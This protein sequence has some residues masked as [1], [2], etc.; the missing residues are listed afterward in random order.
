MAA[1]PWWVT[2]T[3]P[4]AFDQPRPQSPPVLFLVWA[5][6]GRGLGLSPAMI[7]AS[8]ALGISAPDNGTLGTHSGA[9]R[10][11]VLGA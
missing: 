7:Q 4:L 5:N 6:W 8:T 9:D 1:G 2:R 11:Q 3:T 10:A